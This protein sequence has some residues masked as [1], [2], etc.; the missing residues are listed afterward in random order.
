MSFGKT[1]CRNPEQRKIA[2]AFLSQEHFEV[3]PSCVFLCSGAHCALSVILT[4]ASLDGSAIATV[5]L[6]YPNFR[7]MA[8]NHGIKLIAC[9]GDEDKML[10]QALAE[11]ATRA[12]S[13]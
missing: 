5:D 9:A 4:K 7:S 11:A 1:F 13:H 6:T 3:A 12:C 2:A 8:T 10:P